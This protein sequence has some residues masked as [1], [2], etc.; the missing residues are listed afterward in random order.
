M[1]NFIYRDG[2]SDPRESSDELQRRMILY[3]SEMCQSVFTDLQTTGKKYL[4]ALELNGDRSFGTVAVVAARGGEHSAVEHVY[5]DKDGSAEPMK[6]GEKH[7]ETIHLCDGQVRTV[8]GAKIMRSGRGLYIREPFSREGVT[9]DKLHSI[10]TDA[11]T[12]EVHIYGLKSVATGLFESESR[13]AHLVIDKHGRLRGYM[14][15]MGH[16]ELEGIR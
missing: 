2:S 5:E 12:G 3:Q 16:P 9:L 8:N 10:R 7:A 11:S 4:P 6:V 13:Q 14:T 15:L 1:D